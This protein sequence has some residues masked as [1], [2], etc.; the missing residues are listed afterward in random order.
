MFHRTRC[1]HRNGAVILESA[2]VYPAL[3]FI[4]LGLLVGGMGVFRYQQVCHLAREAA[5]WGSA[6]G[7]QYRKDAGIYPGTTGGTYLSMDT[8]PSPGVM[9]YSIDSSSASGTWTGAIY[10]NAIAPAIVGLDGSKLTYQIGWPPVVDGAGNIDYI[11][12]TAVPDNWP[13]SKVFVRITYQ[14]FPEVFLVG[15]F[16]LTATSSMPMTN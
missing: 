9:W 12:G 2:L 13:G 5:R 3:F 8:T 4:L 16:N 15:P 11:N 7:A 1:S 14:W 10:A 6:H